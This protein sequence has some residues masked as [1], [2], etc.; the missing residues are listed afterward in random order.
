MLSR[1]LEAHEIVIPKVR[2]ASS[3]RPPTATTG[4]TICSR[5]DVLR[6]HELQVWF[7]ARPGRHTH[8]S[9][10]TLDF[11]RPRFSPEAVQSTSA[12]TA[13]GA[14]PAG[15]LRP[16]PSRSR[17]PRR[18]TSCRSPSAGSTTSVAATTIVALAV[19]LSSRVSTYASRGNDGRRECRHLTVV[20][21]SS[22]SPRRPA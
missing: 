18:R 8:G 16:R 5:S 10:V 20:A 6:R 14:S 13:G 11:G 9:G 19:L 22:G 15:A 3:E 12:A 21:R 2:D 7:A 17:R 4:R 1:L